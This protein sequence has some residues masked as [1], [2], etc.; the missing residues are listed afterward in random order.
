M[1]NDFIVYKLVQGPKLH[2]LIEEST[3]LD[4]FVGT[5]NKPMYGAGGVHGGHARVRNGIA[6]N[7]AFEVEVKLWG[8][9]LSHKAQVPPRSP[10]F[11]SSQ[12]Q[13]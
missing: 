11:T 5:R 6:F 12:Y 9:L 4:L 2:V 13:V 10:V 1:L 3:L 8:C 7:R